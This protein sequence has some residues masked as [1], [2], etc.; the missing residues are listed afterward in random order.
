[1]NKLNEDLNNN[2][3]DNTKV[4]WILNNNIKRVY[5]N[6]DKQL[7]IN[8]TIYESEYIIIEGAI[9]IISNYNMKVSNI[10]L[11]LEM[12]NIYNKDCKISRENNENNKNITV[13]HDNKEIRIS[14]DKCIELLIH[15][16]QH[17]RIVQLDNHRYDRNDKNNSE[18]QSLLYKMNKNSINTE[19]NISKLMGI[20]AFENWNNGKLYEILKLLVIWR[21]INQNVIESKIFNYINTKL[22]CYNDSINC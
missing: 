21:F 7:K 18:T 1:M 5:M 4:K 9:S 14:I 16:N 10:L 11:E 20:S 17:R 3:V 15:D 19:M 12:D 6:E 8:D 13:R 2:K 22:N